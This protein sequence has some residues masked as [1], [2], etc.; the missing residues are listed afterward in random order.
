MSGDAKKYLQALG[1]EL[2]EALGPGYRF[3]KSALELRAATEAG[4]NLVT[5]GGAMR[6]SPFVDVAFHFGC[7]YSTAKAVAKQLGLQAGPHIVQYSLNR[8]SMKNLPMPGPG[9]G[10]WSV[11]IGTPPDA[12]LVSEM[13]T[14]VR[15]MAVPF[16]ERFAGMA[17][18]RDA[19]A[20]DDSW[21]LGGKMQWRNVLALDVALG[22]LD[23]FRAWA[24][25]LDKLNAQEANDLL[26][27][28]EALRG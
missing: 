13:A 11:H 24:A 23:H 25:R 18:A 17:A 8:A 16:F 20:G 19:V 4:E 22:E 9:R 6:H 15:G 2:A 14:A 21:C 26:L 1:A 12:T 3:Y 28:A 10:S 27:R 5:L 7:S